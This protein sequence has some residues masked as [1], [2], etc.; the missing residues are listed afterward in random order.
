MMDV[1]YS[2]HDT[3]H[4]LSH[5]NEVNDSVYQLSRKTSIHEVPDSCQSAKKTLSFINYDNFKVRIN[6]NSINKTINTSLPMS[7]I[8]EN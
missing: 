1:N 6:R 4:L 8:Q 5:R 3:D 7:N 2:T